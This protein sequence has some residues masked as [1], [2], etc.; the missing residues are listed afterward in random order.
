VSVGY[1]YYNTADDEDSD[2]NRQCVDPATY[3]CTTAC[4]ESGGSLNVNDGK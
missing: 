2:A 1:V 4:G 3:D